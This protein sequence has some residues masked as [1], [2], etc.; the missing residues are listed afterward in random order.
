[1]VEMKIL[2]KYTLALLLGITLLQHARAQELRPRIA[3]LESDSTYMA[4]LSTEQGLTRR[5]DS[6]NQALLLSR[7]RY[8]QAPQE[9]EQLT[10]ALLGLESE[11]LK[12]GGERRRV[13]EQLSHIEQEWFLL[14]HDSTPQTATANQPATGSPE[15]DYSQVPRHRMLVRNACFKQELPEEDYD[16]LLAVQELEQRA[17]L[18]VE[19]Y[20]DNYARLMELQQAHQTTTEQGVAD[21]LY[22]QMNTH[23]EQNR[24]LDDSLARCWNR[25][26]DQ[27]GYA[28]AYLLDRTGI[29]TL[30]EHQIERQNE[31][32]RE[33]DAQEGEYASDALMSYIIEKRALVQ[34]EMELATAFSL[35][36]ARDSLSREAEYLAGVDYR[37]PRIEPERRYLLDYQ[38]IDFPKKVSYTAYTIPACPIYESGTIY[39]IRLM[40]SKYRQQA[41]IFRGVEP[42]YLL[43]EGNR[44]IYFTGGFATLAEATVARELLLKKGFRAPVVVCWVDGELREVSEEEHAVH[45]RVEITGV[46]RLSDEVKTLIQV[47]APE[48]EIA[49]VGSTFIVG[50]FGEESEAEQLAREIRLTE[51]TLE[52]RVAEE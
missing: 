25:I 9:R 30:L 50:G 26:F 29:T 1:M 14:H 33:A 44:Y 17:S 15:R 5:I 35:V 10:E 37:L 22:E 3:G 32:R 27:K 19:R 36:E 8:Q 34:C 20:A 52:V 16:Q 43:R 28:Y 6:L 4:L 23:L 21:S 39:R 46:E 24:Q 42:L 18:L 12:V 2:F 51:G 40:D 11:L 49:R 41:D 38:N 45:Y 7:E 47:Q 13:A 48:R 31:A